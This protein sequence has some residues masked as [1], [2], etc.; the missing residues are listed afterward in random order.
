MTGT[1]LIVKGTRENRRYEKRKGTLIRNGD[2]W[3]G[4]TK[5]GPNDWVITELTTGMRTC[6][7]RLPKKADAES[8]A[9]SSDFRE[10]VRRKFNCEG[11]SLSESQV[12]QIRKS[13][14]KDRELCIAAYC[15]KRNDDDADLAK[16]FM[17]V[18]VR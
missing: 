3:F 13:F 10:V 15:D 4:I 5:E 17:R 14:E 6:L 18:F 8:E 2:M 12:E 7:R 1:Y 11:S 16:T 9:K